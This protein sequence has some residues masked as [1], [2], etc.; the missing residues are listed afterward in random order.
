MRET[1]A[2][3][4]LKTDLSRKKQDIVRARPRL[5]QVILLT[6]E[7]RCTRIL[8]LSLVN[9]LLLASSAYNQTP[10]KACCPT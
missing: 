3:N 7:K 5:L 4:V 10:T 1:Q 6:V 2:F 8:T 9:A